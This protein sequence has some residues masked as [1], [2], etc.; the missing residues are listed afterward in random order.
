MLIKVSFL[1]YLDV[2]DALDKFSQST[3][4]S[5]E[6]KEKTIES[7]FLLF[8]NKLTSSIQNTDYN[9]L[10]D[11]ILNKSSVISE[12]T[13]KS[14]WPMIEILK[15]QNFDPL[16]IYIYNYLRYK[17]SLRVKLNKEILP[18]AFDNLYMLLMKFVEK[19]NT[20]FS[21]EVLWTFFN[22][23]FELYVKIKDNTNELEEIEEKIDNMKL[24]IDEVTSKSNL[25]KISMGY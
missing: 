16:S 23:L 11:L 6:L 4:T 9:S 17:N 22:D 21:D 13:G 8:V 24:E 3:I 1:N 10:T 12:Q 20:P 15:V 14:E 2:T 25:I 18:K 19:V 7:I 5:K